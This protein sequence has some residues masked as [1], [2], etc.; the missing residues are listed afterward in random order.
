MDHVIL[1][2]VRA[3]AAGLMKRKLMTH[4]GLVRKPAGAGS[5]RKLEAT[6]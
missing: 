3:L 6:A 4:R 2:G 5:D 1:D